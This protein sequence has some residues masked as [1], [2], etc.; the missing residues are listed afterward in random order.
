MS[1]VFATTFFFCLLV[2]G[3]GGGGGGVYFVTWLSRPILSSKFLDPWPVS[4]IFLVISVYRR[5]A[6]ITEITVRLFNNYTNRFMRNHIFGI[7]DMH[8]L[9]SPVDV[10]HDLCQ[11]CSETIDN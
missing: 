11:T 8:I 6:K 7:C 9:P 2:G 5:N 3:G 10:Q 1:L 4:I